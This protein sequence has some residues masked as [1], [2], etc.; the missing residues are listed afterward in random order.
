MARSASKSTQP[1]STFAALLVTPP[2]TIAGK[3]TPQGT[4][5]PKIT[6]CSIFLTIREID[7]MT[8]A[9]ADGWGV[10]TR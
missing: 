7:A 6:S 1:G 2:M 10:G 5:E 3:P 8:A 4:S 9:G